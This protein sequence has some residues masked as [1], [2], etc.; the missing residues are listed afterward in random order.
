MRESC[1]EGGHRSAVPARRGV[2]ETLHSVVREGR[3]HGRKVVSHAIQIAPLALGAVLLSA[4]ADQRGARIELCAGILERKLPASEVVEIAPQPSERPAITF[5]AVD[6]EGAPVRGRLE[7]ELERSR[8]GGLRVRSVTLDGRPLS[9]A[10][11]AVLNANLL[12]DDLD[13]IG[14]RLQDRSGKRNG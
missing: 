3:G 10:E 14:R 12:L 6:D 1:G 9:E 5:D 2:P 7:C 4:C 8:A 13:R 11:I